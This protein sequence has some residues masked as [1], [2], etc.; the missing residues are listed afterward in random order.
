MTLGPPPPFS[1]P[2][3]LAKLAKN[4]SA[5]FLGRT[6]D[7]A[8]AKL[9]QL[10][11]DLRLDIIAEQRCRRPCRR[12]R[13]WRHPL[14][15]PANAGPRPRPRSCSRSAG[16]GSLKVTLPL[17][18]ADTGPT[19]IFRD[20][21]E[22][23]WSSGRLK[24]LAAGDAGFS[25]TRPGRLAWPTPLR[26][27]PESWT[28]PVIV[29]RHGGPSPEYPELSPQLEHKG[30]KRKATLGPCGM[31]IRTREM[32]GPKLWDWQEPVRNG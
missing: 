15:K 22:K 16:R 9:S 23:P 30:A 17:K 13:R 4:S 25:T 5:S 6:I 28:S 27:L 26:G 18:R 1:L 7:Q 12:A 3:P 20:R 8:L 24:L 21:R 2:P 14:A 11:A 32:P 10:A 19:F 31:H 29:I